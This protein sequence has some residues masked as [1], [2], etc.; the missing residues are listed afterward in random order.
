MKRIFILIVAMVLVALPACK[1]QNKASQE[2]TEYTP[3]SEQV[4]TDELKANMENLLLSIKQ[5]KPV[6]PMIKKNSSKVELTE[7]EKMVKPDYL[8]DPTKT[9]NLVTLTQKYRLL[10]MLD[11]DK[12]IA[13]LYDLPTDDYTATTTKL[14]AEIN[15]PALKEYFDKLPT[16]EDVTEAFN[17]MI[18]AAY[19]SGR[20]SLYWEGFAA[21][22]VESLFITTRDLDK[23]MPMFDDQSVSD[24]TFNLVCTQENIT[25]LIDYYPE[26]EALN[27]I[28]GPLYVLNAITVDQFRSQ[29]LSVK[30]DIENIRATLLK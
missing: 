11:V 6:L 29:L 24:I 22:L 19:R 30:S 4:L 9:N 23:F 20:A 15:D 28:L 2:A 3:G 5:I 1:N 21:G 12:T 26:M 14:I 16:Q 10:S 25:A 27:E 13:Q 7:K 8:L 17:D 18:A